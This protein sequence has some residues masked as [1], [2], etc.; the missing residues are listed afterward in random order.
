MRFFSLSEDDDISE[1]EDEE[2]EEGGE[3]H[4]DLAMTCAAFPNFRGFGA[5]MLLFCLMTFLW[6]AG[7][8]EM[9]AEKRERNTS[10]FI[11]REWRGG[12]NVEKCE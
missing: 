10:I 3:S 1:D 9:A 12:K 7:M 4:R 5:K 8:A 6:A 2:E 11:T